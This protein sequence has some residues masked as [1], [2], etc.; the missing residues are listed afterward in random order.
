MV[1]HGWGNA[2][3]PNGASDEELVREHTF[4]LKPYKYLKSIEKV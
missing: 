3:W 4:P 2:L 1:N